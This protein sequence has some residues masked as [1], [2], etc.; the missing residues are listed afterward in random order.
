MF[1]FATEIML[2]HWADMTSYCM[3][4]THSERTSIQR[5]GTFWRTLLGLK[6]LSKRASKISRLL[7][8]KTLKLLK[9]NKI[10][11]LFHKL[12]ILYILTCSSAIFDQCA[13]SVRVFFIILCNVPVK[14]GISKCF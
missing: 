11:H 5:F 4:A 14:I 8:V 13:I 1:L 12:F 7:F 10:A 3:V 9:S 6:Y 2:T